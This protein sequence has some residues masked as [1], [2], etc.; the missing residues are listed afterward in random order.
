MTTFAPSRANIRAS[1]SAH[2]PGSAAYQGN[3]TLKSHFYTPDR[4]LFDFLLGYC[5]AMT[6]QLCLAGLA[7]APAEPGGQAQPHQDDCKVA[8]I[9]NPL[10]LSLSKDG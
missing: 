2:A 1:V 5:N 10:V 7:P 4:P 6:P 3:L 9:P 8:E